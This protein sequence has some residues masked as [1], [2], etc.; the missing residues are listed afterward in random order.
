MESIIWGC[1]GSSLAHG[2]VMLHNLRI[3]PFVKGGDADNW[4]LV[5]DY[6]RILGRSEST[7]GSPT[8]VPGGNRP[9]P[10]SAGSSGIRLVEGE[11]LNPAN[12]FP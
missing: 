11:A 5:I 2:L 4:C 9:P 6:R 8:A 12:V 7:G 10:V 3:P 1:L